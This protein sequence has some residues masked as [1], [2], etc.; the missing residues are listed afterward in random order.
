MKELPADIIN[1]W[2]H[3]E[4]GIERMFYGHVSSSGGNFTRRHSDYLSVRVLQ[5]N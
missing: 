3:I 2:I 1:K 4:F 5:E